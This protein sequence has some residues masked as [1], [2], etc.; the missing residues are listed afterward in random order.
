MR[1]SPFFHLRVSRLVVAWCNW[2]GAE[3]KA[4]RR[5]R[6]SGRERERERAMLFPLAIIVISNRRYQSKTPALLS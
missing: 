2:C 1:I 5:E 3:K 4:A 6:V